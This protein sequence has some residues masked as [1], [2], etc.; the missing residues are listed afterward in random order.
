[1]TCECLCVY[2]LTYQLGCNTA[3]Q[4]RVEESG[5]PAELLRLDP[6]ASPFAA[7][8]AQTGPAT[9]ARL[10][11]LAEAAAAARHSGSAAKA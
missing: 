3:L 1:M 2:T 8:V 6:A 7:L 4:G 5:A 10:K 9:A 11:R